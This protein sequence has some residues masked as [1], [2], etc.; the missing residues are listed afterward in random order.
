MKDTMKAIAEWALFF[1]VIVLVIFGVWKL[2]PKGLFGKP[3]LDVTLI[4]YVN[5]VPEGCAWKAVSTC[6][7]KIL[8]ECLTD[9]DLASTD[10]EGRTLLDYAVTTSAWQGSENTCMASVAYLTIKG[11]PLD[12]VDKRGLTSLHY[13]SMSGNNITV[14]YLYRKD[15]ALIDKKD[16]LG[17]TPLKYA[18]T[19]SQ[20]GGDGYTNIITYLQG[21]K[22]NGVLVPVS[23]YAYMDWIEGTV[24]S[25]MGEFDNAIAGFDSSITNCG[26]DNT[27]LLNIGWLSYWMRGVVYDNQKQYD[28]AVADFSSAIDL[29]PEEINILYDR[30]RAYY[31]SGKCEAAKTDLQ[32]YIVAVLTHTDVGEILAGE[33]ASSFAAAQS[34]METCVDK[35]SGE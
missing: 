31:F 5:N 3:K 23:L 28:K 15:N 32:G 19:Y 14:V 26:T 4:E 25:D 30:G 24:Y 9:E 6:D 34:M 18:Q 2:L 1:V 16:D 17:F 10:S 20:L 13:A 29:H 7:Y 27:C 11:I 21:I 33:S 35:Q 8:V 12:K 22:G